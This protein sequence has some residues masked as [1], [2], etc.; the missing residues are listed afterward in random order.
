MT[1]PDGNTVL[2]TTDGTTVATEY[3]PD[4][5][6]GYA[7]PVIAKQTYTT[8]GGR[9]RTRTTTRTAPLSNPQDPFSFTT[10]TESTNLTGSGIASSTSASVYTNATRNLLMTTAANR[11]TSITLDTKGRIDFGT[12]G[13]L[14]AGRVPTDLT[15]DSSG[16]LTDVTEGTAHESATYDSR[17][18]IA[19]RSDATGHTV[20]FGYDA[21]DRP[22]S[23]TDGVGGVS[24]AGYDDEGSVTSITQPSGAAHSMSYDGAGEQSGYTPPGGGVPTAIQRN[25]DGEQTAQNLGGNHNVTIARDAGGRL[26]AVNGAGDDVNVNYFDTTTR[27]AAL[28]V[29]RAGT[30]NDQGLAMEWNAYLPTRIDY[31][32]GT[33]A[34]SGVFTLGYNGADNPTSRR[35]QSGA[36]DVTTNYTYDTD[37]LLLTDGPFTYTRAGALG[38]TTRIAD[39]S[40]TQNLTYDGRG[41]ATTRIVTVPG[42]TQVYREDL[43]IDAGDRLSTRTERFGAAAAIQLDYTY[44]GDGRLTKVQRGGSDSETYGY[45]ANGNRTS[46]TRPGLAGTETSTYDSQG[47]LATRGATAYTFDAGGY[48]AQR[49]ADTF[50]YGP[51][52]RLQSATAGGTTVTYTYDGAGRRTAR[53]VGAQTHQYLYGNPANPWQLSASRDP[54]GQLSQYFYDASDRLHAIQ[55]GATRFYVITDQLGSPRMVTD[56]GGATVKRIDYDAYG[57]VISD[58]APAFDL[59]VGF[60]GGLSDATT[61]LVAFAQRDYEPASARWTSRDPIGFSGDQT[62]LYVYVD[63]DPIN[64]RDPS[65]TIAIYDQYKAAKGQMD[66]IQKLAERAT[67]YNDASQYQRDGSAEIA[68]LLAFIGDNPIIGGFFPVSVAQQ[69]LDK[70]KEALGTYRTNGNER[71]PGGDGKSFD[72]AYKADGNQAP[73]SDTPLSEQASDMFWRTAH[74]L[75]R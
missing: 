11:R 26:S 67:T 12:S 35:L 47:R 50:S 33:A 46:R 37:Q 27:P 8:P 68:C 42:A 75:V 23:M 4:P 71:D 22:T 59:P 20:S 36:D 9:T 53:T 15:Y 65:G 69:A 30:A 62:N 6:F 48:L 1:N 70:G 43:A 57:D 18:R 34:A 55:R 66:K 74:W 56:S 38:E 49:G 3:G 60:A 29:D 25:S 41:R 19:S 7:V 54:G 58:S 2:T 72:S 24:Q 44:D 45:D 63:D 40:M 17:D 28:N 14:P 52:G 16:R 32:G 10:F 61:G 51:R 64:M 73:A 31:G 13:T 21:A 39:G 5:R